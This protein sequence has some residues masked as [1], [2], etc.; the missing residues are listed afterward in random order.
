MSLSNGVHEED[1][2]EANGKNGVTVPNGKNEDE[3]LKKKEML[4]KILE[5]FIR[6]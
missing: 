1:F 5:R 3:V 6:Y 2:S 4:V